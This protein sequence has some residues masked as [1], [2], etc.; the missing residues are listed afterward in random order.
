[1]H[2]YPQSL[3]RPIASLITGL[4]LLS[5]IAALHAQPAAPG[6]QAGGPRPQMAI[7][8]DGTNSAVQLPA[9]IFN[10]LSEATI[11]AW[12]KFRDLSGSRFYSYGGFYQDLCVGRRQP[13]SGQSLD[14]FVN[15]AGNLTEVVV[16]GIIQ[17]DVWYHIA[18]VLGSGG[19]E[20]VVDGV[21]AGA[22]SSSASFA[23]M[24]AGELNFIG[25]MNGGNIGA[26]GVFFDGQ[27]AEF[28]VWK[29][30][31]T[32]EEIR[33]N[34][35]RHLNGTEPGL[36]GLW[37]FE[38]ITSG[39]VRD[40]SPGHHDGKLVGNARAVS[41][42]LPAPD[43]L[44]VP[45]VVA[46]TVRDETGKPARNATIRL[47]HGA[48]VLSEARSG[49]DGTYSLASGVAYP[50]LDI[51]ASRGELGAWKEDTVCTPGRLEID[52]TL[53]NAVSIAGQVTSFDGSVVPDVVVHLLRGDAPVPGPDSLAQVGWLATAITG[54][55]NTSQSYRFV[56]LRPGGYKVVLNLPDTLLAYHNGE[57]LQVRPG[58][59]VSADFQIAPVHK[60]RWRRYSTAHG[61]PS[62][63][64]YDLCFAPNGILWLATPNGVSRFDGVKF[65]SLSESEGLL[66]RRVFCIY[67]QTN[68]LLWFGTEKGASRYDPQ[69]GRFE[70]FLSGTN[71]LTAGR[72]FDITAAPDG[73]F[74]LRTREGLTR[75]DGQVFR[76]VPGIPRITQDPSNTKTEALLVD[77]LGRVWTVTDGADLWRVD[78]TNLVRFST[79]DGLAD[80][81]QDGLC[82]ETNGALWFQDHGD[83]F[84][85]VTRYDGK[86]FQHLSDQELGI[87]DIVC[88]IGL[89]AGGSLWFGCADGTVTRYDVHSGGLEHFPRDS[90]GPSL[91]PWKIRTGPDGAIWFASDT[92]L[93]RYDEETLVNYTTADG[94]PNNKVD[95]GTM[96]T[97]GALW[98]SGTAYQSQFLVRFDPTQTNR[99][100]NRFVNTAAEG[101]PRAYVIAMAPD[102][103][104]GLW[105]G[106]AGQSAGVY[107][108]DRSAA[109][110]SEEPFRQ[111]PGPPA[112][113]FGLAYAL[114]LDSQ[115]NLWVGEG[116]AGLYRVPLADIWTTHPV[117]ER[118][119]TNLV[120]VLYLDAHGAIWTAFSTTRFGI[121]QPVSRLLGG[122]VQYFSAESAPGGLPSDFVNCFQEGPDGCV[123][124]GTR[125]GLARFDG[126]QFS[127]LQG[128]A[129]RPVPAGR[130]W[131]ILRDA[132]GVLWFAT[133]S[134]LYSYDGIAWSFLD[135]EDGLEDYNVNTII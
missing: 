55:T 26:P 36:A 52:L 57:V 71:G 50:S 62:T 103:K 34:M 68:G 80:L 132:D 3:E 29:T 90:G 92:G 49:A 76:P 15:N 24:Q 119:G 58:Q 99:W 128:T 116:N 18:A 109:A 11:E 14:V 2:S 4:A 53:Q 100:V 121:R 113:Q 41:A 88:S 73:M 48:E 77:R 72:V 66:D 9:N 28:R 115:D 35:F 6:P 107:H 135:Q 108:Y 131:N 127:T 130:I 95:F 31:R 44:E 20:L 101:M 17:T 93:Y 129:D 32:P 45:V 133:D 21:L 84:S 43:Q 69:S 47:R 10:G 42:R 40:L 94:L 86:G 1:M 65:T 30:R 61:L 25:R 79:R 126:K 91:T 67:A 51:Q 46:G 27:V 13:Y 37:A 74:W 117:A 125:E 5:R 38:N 12:V 96:T 64:V 7:D 104:G 56:N 85:G 83:R 75:F 112:V 110:R 120:D 114:T 8:L 78:G 63:R 98:V 59:T 22:N 39:V 124:A 87:D 16:P 89:G 23:T 111:V 118:V 70:N 102:R 105:L 81:Y 97:D 82:L 33:L 19:M 106:G 60:G 54:N 123:Y 122:Q 134:G